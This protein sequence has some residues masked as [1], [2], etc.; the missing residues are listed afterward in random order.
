MMEAGIEEARIEL[1]IPMLRSGFPAACEIAK[2]KATEAK[3][4]WKAIAG[5]VWG[6]KKGEEWI[7]PEVAAPEQGDIDLAASTVAQLEQEHAELQQHLGAVIEK[8]NTYNQKAGQIDA[9]RAKVAQLPR[10][11]EKLVRDEADLAGYEAELMRLQQLA[12]TAPREGLVHDM[13]RFIDKVVPEVS[14]LAKDAAARIATEQAQLLYRYTQEHGPIST[15]GDPDAQAKIPAI[16]KSVELMRNCVANDKRDIA[17]AEQAEANLAVLGAV[18]PIAAE[19]LQQAKDDVAAHKK[20]LD[21]AKNDHAGLLAL[22]KAAQERD[23]ITAQAKAHHNDIV[24]WLK[25]AEQFAPDG[26]PSQ[27]LAKALEPI[28]KKLREYATSTEWFQ[29]TI[30][31]DMEIIANSRPLTLLSESER[32]M[33]NAHI[34][35]AIA[36]LSDLKLLVLDRFDVLDVKHRPQLLCWLDDL[37]Y[38]QRLDTALVF[39]TLKEPPKGLPDSIASFWIQDGELIEQEPL[40][41][42]A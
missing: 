7:A 19:L 35:A 41:Q 11:R 33:A 18:E 17:A 23:A 15:A 13:A 24:G 22:Q 26:L 36:E 40:K 27:I 28:N 9:A 30:R 2:Q 14:L 32:W 21:D 25:V 16:E 29:V 38:E 34:A 42:A 37:G 1:A 20:E 3:G 8:M 6:S 31:P 12:G 4:A 5:G 39:G 10:L